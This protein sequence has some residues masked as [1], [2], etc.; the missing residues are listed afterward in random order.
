MALQ[1]ANQFQ[2]V[3]EIARAGTGFL[4]GQQSAL[5]RQQGQRAQ[6]QEQRAATADDQR[7]S[8]LRAK[9]LNDIAIDIRNLPM[10]QREGA[11]QEAGSRMQGV[12]INPSVFANKPLDNSTLDQVIAATGGT[13]AVKAPTRTSLEKNLV[14]AGFKPGTP[15]FEAEVLKN[16]NK[17]SG[18]QITIGDSG[19]KKFSEAIASSQAK[20]FTRVQEEADAAIDTNQSLDVME[21]ID[22]ETGALEPLKQGLSKWGAAFGLDTSG[23]ANVSAGEAF[24]AEAKRLVLS[25]KAS[26]KGPQT[27]K[28]EATIRSTVA[29]LGNTKEGNKFIIDSARALNNRRIERKEFYD[30]FLEETGGK[31]KNEEGKTADSAWSSYK[32]NTP[33][34]SKNLR[35]P[36][37]LPVFFY[38]FE[39]DV[40]AANPDASRAEILEAWRA[41]DKGAK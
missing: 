16:I 2:L 30:K 3:P 27:D 8:E 18:T 21:N 23:I 28:D 13:A 38:K 26:Q 31:Y 19:D 14:A 7:Q 24:N 4:Q 40:R 17:P 32:R 29:N 36:D 35:T 33:M 1:T 10:D 5:A 39:E 12:N 22:V 34:L 11:L 25:V 20:T 9:V 41:A 37:G 6:A 15:E